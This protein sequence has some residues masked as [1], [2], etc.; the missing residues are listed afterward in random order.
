MTP[1]APSPSAPPPDGSPCVDGQFINVASL[2]GAVAA[3][4]ARAATGHGFTFFTL[5]LDHLVKLREHAGFRD[6]YRRA[7]FVSAD[8]WPV[9]LLAGRGGSRR[10]GA[11]VRVTTGADLVAPLCAAAAR[12]GVPVYLF[13][14]TEESLIQAAAALRAASPGLDIRGWHAPPF[15]F[16]P[17]S[18]AAGADA[19]RIAASGA[20]LVFVALG[21]PKQ[22]LFSARAATR[23]PGLGLVCVGAALDFLSGA[24]VRAPRLVRAARLEWLWRLAH[25]PRALSGRY[26]RCAALLVGLALVEPARRA[27]GVRPDGRRDARDP[28]GRSDPPPHRLCLMAAMDPRGADGGGLAGDVHRILRHHPADVSILFVGLDTVGDGPLGA[29]RRLERDGRPFDFLPVARGRAGANP[30]LRHGLGT[31]RHLGAIRR[32]LGPGPATAHLHRFGLAPLARRLGLPVIQAIH[33]AGGPGDPAGPLRFVRT[34]GEGWA[35]RRAAGI[36]CADPGAVRRIAAVFPRALPKVEMLGPCVDTELFRARAFA[37]DDGVLRLFAETGDAQ[38]DPALV[39]ATLTALGV[40]LAGRV[41]LHLVGAGAP[42]R[43]PGF[44]ALRALAVHHG[45]QDPAGLARILAR[46]HVGLLVGACAGLPDLLLAGLATGRPFGALPSA[47]LEGLI[48]DGASGVLVERGPDTGATA[49]DLAEHVARLWDAVR[50]GRVD[51][52]AIHARVAPYAVTA[53]M[54]R[55]FARHRAAGEEARAPA[56]PVTAA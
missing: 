37:A 31:L 15:G 25:A 34:L 26:A 43:W 39:G 38:A 32:A 10:G 54:G 33:G 52:W 29:V 45:V 47:A 36:V 21:A 13:G 16:D 8:G 40:R 17:L 27:L 6:A 24:Q 30:A 14:A 50:Q 55:L 56:R 46:C 11:A 18:A 5:N 19:D 51:P 23:H 9:A 2:D 49:R 22:E 12:D 4:R 7:N 44:P 42:E 1:T 3:V 20:R 35:L 28:P 48:E 41:E 53:R